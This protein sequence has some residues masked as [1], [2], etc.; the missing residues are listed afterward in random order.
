[1]PKYFPV[2]GLNLKL[3]FYFVVKPAAPRNLVV[4]FETAKQQDAGK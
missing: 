1:M 3:L 4:L 2:V